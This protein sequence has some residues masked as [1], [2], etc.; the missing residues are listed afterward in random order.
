MNQEGKNMR[1]FQLPIQSSQSFIIK[2]NIVDT[3]N[4]LDIEYELKPFIAVWFF[5]IYLIFL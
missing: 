2:E 4:P 5:I 1:L 3:S